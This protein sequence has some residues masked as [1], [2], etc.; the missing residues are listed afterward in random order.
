MQNEKKRPQWIFDVPLFCTTAATEMHRN[1][2]TMFV[3]LLRAISLMVASSCRVM[4]F[5]F[6]SSSL[7]MILHL[8][9][10]IISQSP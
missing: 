7:R 5:F 1:I 10:D 3:L 9:C 6:L 2:L 8:E 4:V